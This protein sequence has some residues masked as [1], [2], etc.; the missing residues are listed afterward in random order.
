MEFP[1]VE[2]YT[3]NGTSLSGQRSNYYFR[4][5]HFQDQELKFF[6]EE[7]LTS[8]VKYSNN[9]INI[10]D[11][12]KYF[13]SDLETI[14]SGE[15]YV[16]NNLYRLSSRDFSDGYNLDETGISNIDLINNSVANGTCLSV[17]V[18]YNKNVSPEIKTIKIIRGDSAFV[19]AGV[20]AVLNGTNNENKVKDYFS[21]IQFQG[22]VTDTNVNIIFEPERHLSLAADFDVFK[23]P[24]TLGANNQK[25]FICYDQT[26]RA[27]PEGYIQT[28]NTNGSKVYTNL[29]CPSKTVDY[30]VLS[31]QGAICAVKGIENPLTQD[32]LKICTQERDS[33]VINFI[34]SSDQC[35][36]SPD[37][38]EYK[39]L[40]NQL[41]FGL[42][43]FPIEKA[44]TLTGLSQNTGSQI[45]NTLN[46]YPSY[47]TKEYKENRLYGP[48]EELYI[49]KTRN[50]YFVSLS[51]DNINFVDNVASWRRVFTFENNDPVS[52]FQYFFN[53]HPPDYIPNTINLGLRKI[54]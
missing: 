25:N 20:G 31:D 8:S 53:V 18:V 33:K 52:P 3:P 46:T 24:Y 7:I 43:L 36:I 29:A 41:G 35:I 54:S 38:S 1:G 14:N 44:L 17:A 15:D 51:N 12:K 40:N 4:P 9:Y 13:L 39:T 10:F 32:N 28:I 34:N 16:Q 11:N 27:R 2:F 37:S 19:S 42:Q 48:M 47:F 6:N 23:S 30:E 49:E 45:I 26:G 50:N 21:M 5:S 22:F